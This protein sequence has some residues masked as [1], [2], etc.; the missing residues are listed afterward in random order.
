VPDDASIV[1]WALVQ[2]PSATEFA[3]QR[4]RRIRVDRL[5]AKLAVVAHGCDRGA[6]TSVNA[7]IK[8]S[9]NRYDYSFVSMSACVGPNAPRGDVAAIRRMVITAHVGDI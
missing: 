2:I 6:G 8:A 5:P 4:G 3:I 1:R 9:R 7:A